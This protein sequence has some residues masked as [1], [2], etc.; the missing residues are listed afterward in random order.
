MTQDREGYEWPISC[1]KKKL[2]RL[3]MKEDL[4]VSFLKVP[5]KNVI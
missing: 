4:K 1:W 3:F 5:S 2:C